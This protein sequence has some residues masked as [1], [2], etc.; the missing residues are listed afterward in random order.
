MEEMQRTAEQIDEEKKRDE[1]KLFRPQV[2]LSEMFDARDRCAEYEKIPRVS[3][4]LRRKAVRAA[5]E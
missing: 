2:F 4:A 5:A 3:A 1:G